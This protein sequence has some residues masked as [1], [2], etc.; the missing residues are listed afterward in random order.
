VRIV[1]VNK[2][3]HV[4]GGAD[5]HCLDLA[6]AL[7]AAGHEVRMLSTADPAN[8]WRSGAFILCSAARGL[9]P[10]AAALF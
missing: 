9:G 4:T 10:L 7:T 5:Q 6:A 3:A 2:F 1:L 8:G